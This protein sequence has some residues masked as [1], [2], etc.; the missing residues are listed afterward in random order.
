MENWIENILDL[1]GLFLSFPVIELPIKQN[2][3]NASPY[4]EKIIPSTDH[5]ILR[6]YC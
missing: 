6:L 4:F 5:K 3:V 1:E 2:I